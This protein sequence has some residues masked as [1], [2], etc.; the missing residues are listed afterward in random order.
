LNDNSAGVLYRFG[1]SYEIQQVAS[2]FHRK[3][4]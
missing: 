1:I 3:G 4:Q 2:L